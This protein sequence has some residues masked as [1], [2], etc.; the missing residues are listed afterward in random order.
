[1]DFRSGG[2]PRIRD[3]TMAAGELVNLTEEATQHYEHCFWH[4][5]D[6]N[7]QIL[8]PPSYFR[9]VQDPFLRE[10]VCALGAQTSP[11]PEAK[12]HSRAFAKRV[13]LQNSQVCTT[14]F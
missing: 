12:L 4:F 3:P 1:M 6:T 14:F 9:R 2:E 11:R 7:F 8:H 13:R 10:V 5:V